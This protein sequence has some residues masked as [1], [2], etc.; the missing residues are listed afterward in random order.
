LGT[1]QGGDTLPD[2]HN[3][4]FASI[5]AIPAKETRRGY[6]ATDLHFSTRESARYQ[7]QGH[8][9]NNSHEAYR[10]DPAM[11]IKYNDNIGIGT[12]NPKGQV[13]IRGNN[14]GD[15]AR[16]TFQGDGNGVIG[17][18]RG[19]ASAYSITTSDGSTH[20]YNTK[21]S[22]AFYVNN[23]SHDDINPEDRNTWTDNEI[24]AM[25]ITSEG[26]VGI[27]TNSPGR[28]LSVIGTMG[29][30][31]IESGGAYAVRGL[32]FNNVQH[33]INISLHGLYNLN[34]SNH[35]NAMVI[36]QFKGM[37]G[38]M[39]S[40]TSFKKVI[41]IE[42]LTEWGGL[43]Q[44]DVSGYGSSNVNITKVSGSSTEIV[45]HVPLPAGTNGAFK[46]E[47]VG[48]N[49][50]TIN[51]ISYSVPTAQMPDEGYESIPQEESGANE[52]SAQSA[53]LLGMIET[54]KSEVESLKTQLKG[55]E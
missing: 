16:I 33:G 6:G 40:Y 26:K 31:T 21:G 20:G 35:R 19:V 34:G 28:Q 46:I 50:S 18:V 2:D 3:S 27:G 25:R 37:T 47:L 10:L 22:L 17:S 4:G 24:E 13:S 11:V 30:N 8:T 12:T 36:I 55:I 54:L 41:H 15:K 53:D 52:A 7:T 9:T 23:K 39:A 29:A 32:S 49:H 42:G 51:P 44:T 45:L 48:A 14:S 1:Y 5:N 43:S 38:N